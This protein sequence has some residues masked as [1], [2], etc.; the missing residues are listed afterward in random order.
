MHAVAFAY[1]DRN[2]NGD[3]IWDTNSYSKCHSDADGITN[4]NTDAL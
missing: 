3:A 4:T 1:A 2:S